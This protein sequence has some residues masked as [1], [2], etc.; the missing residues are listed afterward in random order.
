MCC[1]TQLLQFLL[2]LFQVTSKCAS[3]SST[4]STAHQ[5]A[6]V[7]F[8]CKNTKTQNTMQTYMNFIGRTSYFKK[9]LRPLAVNVCQRERCI[10]LFISFIIFIEINI[11]LR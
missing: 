10:H 6:M 5:N 4:I 8:Q 9:T 2:W 11:F 1:Y 7:G 3:V